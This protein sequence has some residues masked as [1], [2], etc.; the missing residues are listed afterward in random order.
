MEGGRAPLL[1]QK[2]VPPRQKIY[3][4]LTPSKKQDFAAKASKI[5][6]FSEQKTKIS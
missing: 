1:R 4:V 6:G 5:L 2:T 3:L